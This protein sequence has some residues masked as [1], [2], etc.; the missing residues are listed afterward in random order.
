MSD[1]SSRR[2]FLETTVGAAALASGQGA[3]LAQ[4][5]RLRIGVVG[6]GFGSSFPWHMHPNCQVTAVADL[7][8]DRRKRLMERFDCSTSYGDFR[9]MLKNPQVD[10]VAVYSGAPDHVQHAVEVMNSGK[11]VISAVPAATTLEDCQRLVDAVKK[12]GQTYMMAETSCFHAPTM[13]ARKWRKEGRFGRLYYTEGCYLHDHG[14]YLVKGTASK[15]LMDMF[16]QDGKPTWR[17]GNAPG[18]YLTHASGPCIYVSGEKYTE[19][20]AIGTP[21]DH[22]FYKKNQY[23]NPFIDITF[24]FKTSGGNSSRIAIHWWTGASG[25]EGADY[26]GTEMA[27]FEPR[28]GQPAMVSYPSK[29]AEPYQVDNYASIL[30]E[31]LRDRVSQGHGGAEVFIVHEFVSACLERRQPAV[32]VYHAVAYTAPGLV[33]QQ[34][35]MKGG[36]WMKIPDYGP[37]S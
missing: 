20:A 3:A 33:G 6:G 9:P 23:N 16:L 31:N 12:T 13:V 18:L 21:L 11:H 37:I 35:A 14:S 15:Q 30:P 2:G 25:R 5:K 24:F 4:A 34:S 19:V 26:Y 8:D 28:F 27:F 29:K 7:R 10:A 22:P 32:D 17:Y 1:R 36:Q